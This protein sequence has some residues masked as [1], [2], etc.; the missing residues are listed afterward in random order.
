MNLN[1]SDDDSPLGKILNIHNVVRLITSV[2]N[3]NY[4]H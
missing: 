4:K 2:F 3:D 1:N